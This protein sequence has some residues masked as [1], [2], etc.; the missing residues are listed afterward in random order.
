M[1]QFTLSDL[2]M[3]LFDFRTAEIRI[4]GL[5]TQFGNLLDIQIPKLPRSFRTSAST[6][7]HDFDIKALIQLQHKE[8]PSR[9]I[10]PC[11]WVSATITTAY[12]LNTKELKVIGL[13]SNDLGIHHRFDFFSARKPIRIIKKAF[14]ALADYSITDYPKKE[15]TVKEGQIF[16]IPKTAMKGTAWD[17]VKYPATTIQ[18]ITLIWNL[19]HFNLLEKIKSHIE[20]ASNQYKSLDGVDY[21]GELVDLLKIKPDVNNSDYKLCENAEARCDTHTSTF[22]MNSLVE[23]IRECSDS[24]YIE[25]SRLGSSFNAIHSSSYRHNQNNN[26]KRI[27]LNVAMGYAIPCD[28]VNKHYDFEVV[29]CVTISVIAEL[30]EQNTFKAINFYHLD[31]AVHEKD[32][33]NPEIKIFTATKQK[34]YSLESHRK[35]AIADNQGL[36]FTLA[37][38]P[39]QQEDGTAIEIVPLS[40]EANDCFRGSPLAIWNKPVEE[41]FRTFAILGADNNHRCYGLT[42]FHMIKHAQGR[43]LRDLNELI[44]TELDVNLQYVENDLD[45]ALHYIQEAFITT[46]SFRVRN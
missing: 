18:P 25:L 12:N 13:G 16:E 28:V 43:K 26:D 15:L 4:S 5:D 39:F 20:S 32:S 42:P 45:N 27:V 24:A 23:N 14:K 11:A 6:V 19:E 7:F 44:K 34:D 38:K 21:F 35:Y 2:A 3:S 9:F 29:A 30:N 40:K 8:T 31:R 1:R 37:D 36:D 17:D 33:F 22:A 46:D 41:T 10:A